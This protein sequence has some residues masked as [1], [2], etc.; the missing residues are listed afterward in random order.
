MSDSDQAVRDVIQARKGMLAAAIVQRQWKLRPDLERR[1]GPEGYA[2]CLEDAQFHLQ[3]LAEAIGASEPKLFSDYITWAKV[4]L[5]SRKIPTEDLW[6]HLQVVRDVVADALPEDMRGTA[7]AY[8]NSAIETFPRYPF[9]IPTLLDDSNPL[10]EL[11]RSYLTSL[12]RFERHVATKLIQDAVESGASIK[13]IYCHVFESCQREIGRLWQLNSATVAQEHYCTASTQLVMALLYPRMFADNRPKIGTIVA[14]C[15]PG[16]LHELGPRI[17]CDLLEMEGWDTIYLG[18][19]LPQASFLQTV[20]A[21]RPAMVAIS[22]TMT[23]HINAV[24]QVVSA[25]RSSDVDPEMKIMVGGY[26]F[27]HSPELWRSVGADGYAVDASEA[28][29]LVKR[30]R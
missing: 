8:V 25:L 12:L 11:A 18:A 13:D 17:L 22:A 27:Q 1:Y 3:Y 2:K 23:F 30:L 20:K 4:M 24:R 29:D 21:R 10:S 16:E 7:Q 9:E 28:I 6:S 15:V 14:A 19:N 5:G 26:A